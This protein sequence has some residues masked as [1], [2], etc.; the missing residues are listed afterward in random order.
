VE[1]HI[2]WELFPQSKA[3]AEKESHFAPWNTSVKKGFVQVY[4][5]F[6]LS[7]Q[8]FWFFGFRFVPRLP[9]FT[10]HM[11]PV[12]GGSW[13]IYLLLMSYKNGWEVWYWCAVV[14]VF[15]S[16]FTIVPVHCLLFAF[17]ANLLLTKP[18]LTV[19]DN[20]STHSVTPVSHHRLPYFCHSVAV[21]R[22]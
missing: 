20:C 15:W 6:K 5:C 18:S 3:E 21:R 1:F 10:C 2:C 7:R 9:F 13:C 12:N 4:D 22:M 16:L 17:A 14:V 8:L 11:S 19:V